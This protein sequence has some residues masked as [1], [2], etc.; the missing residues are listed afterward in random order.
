M[1]FRLI[2]V[3]R[4]DR[5]SEKASELDKQ[6]KAKQMIAADLLA[7]IIK[8]LEGDLSWYIDLFTVRDVLPG[9]TYGVDICFHQGIDCGD[10]AQCGSSNQGQPSYQ[11]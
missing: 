9:L 4:I 10:H 6:H 1:G 5:I 11:G 8:D 7:E 3:R 2:T